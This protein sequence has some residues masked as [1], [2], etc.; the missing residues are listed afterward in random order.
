MSNVEYNIVVDEIITI[1]V[2]VKAV[3]VRNIK[4]SSGVN[5]RRVSSERYR[6]DRKRSSITDIS[7]VHM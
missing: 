6:I 1:K 5:C 4:C 2:K 3:T 7:G